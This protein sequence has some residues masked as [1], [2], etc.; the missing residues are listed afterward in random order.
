MSS[1]A[2]CRPLGADPRSGRA[3]CPRLLLRVVRPLVVRPIASLHSL[4]ALRAL[5]PRRTAFLCAGAGAAIENIH[6]RARRAAVAAIDVRRPRVA[7]PGATGAS[8][9]GGEGAE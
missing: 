8:G 9:A 5:P 2:G 7:S 3:F 1:S 6:R 4:V